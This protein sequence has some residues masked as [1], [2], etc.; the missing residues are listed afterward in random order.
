MFRP[1]TTKITTYRI[2]GS[3]MNES[4]VSGILHVGVPAGIAVPIPIHLNALD[5]D[6]RMPCM[7][8][9]I[10]WALEHFASSNASHT[11]A[12]DGMQQGLA[13]MASQGRFSI[14]QAELNATLLRSST[15]LGY[16]GLAALGASLTKMVAI[17]TIRA[18]AQYFLEKTQKESLLY[19][20]AFQVLELTD[21]FLTKVGDSIDIVI[22]ISCVISY[23]AM[24][25]FGYTTPG[26]IGLAGC[27]LIFSKRNYYL[28]ASV[29]PYLKYLADLRMVY[30][31]ISSPDRY[32]LV[33]ILNLLLCAANALRHPKF[34]ALLDT[35][36][37]N[38]FQNPYKN[39]PYQTLKVFLESHTNFDT[40]FDKLNFTIREA[41]LYDKQVS[42]V[43]PQDCL[44]GLDSV[45]LKDL[46]EQAEQRM[47]NDDVDF[48]KKGWERLR[49]CLK[50]T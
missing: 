21:R 19:F 4:K 24:I 36:L 16:M 14:L 15:V 5:S 2:L 22:N 50:I 49:D 33:R 38:D 34:L 35:Y 32:L 8:N 29:E 31:N 23:M 20:S 41:A 28:P 37:G 17:P 18:A 42:E 30:N 13:I 40:E 7:V 47:T 10:S 46:F 45:D 25:A 26:I 44:K 39:I 9:H 1:P 12:L 43:L 27:C 48:C 3:S 6:V 11:F